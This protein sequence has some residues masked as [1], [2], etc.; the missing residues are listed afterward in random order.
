M[1]STAG[2]TR[3]QIIYD[4]LPGPPPYGS[5]LEAMCILVFRY[6]QHLALLGA[7]AQA[8]AALGG[9]AAEKAFQEFASY[10]SRVETEDTAQKMRERLK[11]L[12]KIKEIRL[13]PLVNVEQR[14]DN[15][16]RFSRSDT[17]DGEATVHQIRP[18]PRGRP[19]RARPP[20]R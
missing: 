17:L 1:R 18:V 3:A 16:P 7:K 8:Q 19:A 4:K 2:W 12:E 15:I 11:D 5:L 10:Y 13:H 6:R 14:N 9:E 20:K